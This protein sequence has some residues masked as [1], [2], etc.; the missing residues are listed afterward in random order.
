VLGDVEPPE[1]EEGEG[2]EGFA[3]GDLAD[4]EIED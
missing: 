4:V 3:P 2:E 1:G